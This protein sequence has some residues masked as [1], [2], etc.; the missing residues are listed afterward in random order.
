MFEL[1]PVDPFIGVIEYNV[2]TINEGPS[3]LMTEFAN[4]PSRYNITQMIFALCHNY[5]H[6][7]FMA[8]ISIC[9]VKIFPNCSGVLLWYGT[10]KCI[11]ENSSF[12]SS[13]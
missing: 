1:M 5:I 3:M 8:D 10:F 11:R 12:T 13:R 7:L 4:K 9:L 6:A 2:L